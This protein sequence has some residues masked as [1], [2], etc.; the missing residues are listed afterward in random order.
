MPDTIIEFPKGAR[1]RRITAL[2]D[3]G[4]R[5]SGTEPGPAPMVRRRADLRGQTAQAAALIEIDQ[6]Y[7][8]TETGRPDVFK[9]LQLLADGISALERARVAA[10]NNDPI[11]AD[12]FVLRFQLM[13][14]GLFSCRKVG[15]GYALIV[16]SL[17]FAFINQHGM[18]LT[19]DQMTAVWRIL[20]EL[21]TRPF[22]SF[23]QGLVY[24]TELDSHGLQV[25]PQILSELVTDPSD[26]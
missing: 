14:P 18:P 25:D 13:L 26:E 11:T 8:A 10:R 9:A 6:L 19:P 20:R 3:T 21:R 7:P 16:N 5:L 24:V 23:D 1:P 12:R 22:L 2:Q 4:F 15:D 17:H